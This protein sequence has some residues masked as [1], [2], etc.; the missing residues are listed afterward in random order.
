MQRLARGLAEALHPWAELNR[1]HA[2]CL[3]AT[4]AAAPSLEAPHST[5]QRLARRRCTVECGASKLG[6]AHVCSYLDTTEGMASY[7]PVQRL[8]WRRH[9]LQCSACELGVAL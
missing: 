2:K 1:E 5:V 9:T 6:A 4:A 3:Q 8:A 7:R